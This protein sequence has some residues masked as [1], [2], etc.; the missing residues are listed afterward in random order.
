[1]PKELPPGAAAVQ[2]ALQAGTGAEQ[3]PTTS[4]LE[5][6]AGPQPTAPLPSLPISQFG[7]DAATTIPRRQESLPSAT[8]EMTVNIPTYVIGDL[9]F[10]H[11]PG[12]PME[13][14]KMERAARPHL[15]TFV[16]ANEGIDLKA[17]MTGNK[18]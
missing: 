9:S 10:E 13:S 2:A 15:E 16:T 1:M 5:R 18:I 12:S 6:S 14:E 11:D 8:K 17:M 4:P 3:A 7:P